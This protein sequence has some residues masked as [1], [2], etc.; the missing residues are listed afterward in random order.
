MEID[1]A[2]GYRGNDCKNNL[3]FLKNGS[4]LYHT[5]S[6]AVVL[7]QTVNEQKIF[8]LHED[9]I[10]SLDLHPDGIRVATGDL[11]QAVIYVWDS[12]TMQP[13]CLLQALSD[14]VQSLHFSPAGDKLLALG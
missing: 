1:Y 12:N 6:L 5:A 7:D 3:R 8:D 13:L 10:I 11:A 14:G 2:F 4:I 9:D